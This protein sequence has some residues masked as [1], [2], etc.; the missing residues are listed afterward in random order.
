MT[1]LTRRQTLSLAT[2]AAFCAGIGPALS[3]TTR[4]STDRA[5]R[6][7]RG[8]DT[9][10]YW[11]SG[12]ARPG[13]AGLTVDW[14]GATWAFASQDDADR[15]AATPEAFAPQFGGF[16]TRA[17]SLEKVVDG[18]PE[19]WRIFEDRLYLFAKPKGLEVFNRDEVTMIARARDYWNSLG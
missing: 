16:C 11:H 1:R 6:A 10:A 18:D 17:M 14:R 12:M 5:G 7:I 4:V 13:D 9:R 19:V 3:T 2:A 15:F 8:Y